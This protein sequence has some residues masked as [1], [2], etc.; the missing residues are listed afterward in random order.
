[1]EALAGAPLSEG[2]EAGARVAEASARL[3]AEEAATLAEGSIELAPG[4]SAVSFVAKA[5]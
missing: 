1:M 2:L 4:S 3:E 5:Q